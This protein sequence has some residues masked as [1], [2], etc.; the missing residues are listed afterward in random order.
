MN[1]IKVTVGDCD[2]NCFILE[3]PER[4]AV[5]IDPGA[6]PEIISGALEEH[7]LTPAKI[8]LTHGHFDH[9]GAVDALKKQY[10][11][12]LF[13]SRE[14][15]CMLDS[16][17][18]S[19][20]FLLPSAPFHP[21]EADVRISDGAVIK[22]GSLAITV[23]ATPGHSA[24]SVCYIT[25]DVMFVGDTIFAGSVG[26]CDLYSGDSAAQRKTLE[27][28]AAIET[29][30]KLYCGHGEETTLFTEKKRNP[31]LKSL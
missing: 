14:D 23:M 22:Q 13:V 18:K 2:E 12:S 20:A 24:G 4:T 28:L 26:R 21:V 25:E 19:G 5:I 11:C 7:G 16:Y 3:A 17:Q 10:G 27:K 1:I 6:A 31:F 9:I 15:E 30:Y 8:L 29:D